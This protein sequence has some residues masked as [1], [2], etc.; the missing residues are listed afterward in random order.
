[1]SEGA[2]DQLALQRL[3]RP[4]SKYA[5]ALLPFRYLLILSELAVAAINV[6]Y[7]SIPCILCTCAWHTVRHCMVHL[8]ANP[9]VAVIKCQH[10]PCMHT[11]A[12]PRNVCIRL[13]YNSVKCAMEVPRCTCKGPDVCICMYSY[14]WSIV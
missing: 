11:P 1:M 5:A 9:A 10:V 2:L 4:G 13:V 6:A 7:K 14:S 12:S 3:H 8:N